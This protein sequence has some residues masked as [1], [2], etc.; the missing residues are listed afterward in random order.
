[1]PFLL[2]LVLSGCN[3]STSVKVKALI[4]DLKGTV[5]PAPGVAL[6]ALPY[7]RDSLIAALEARAPSPRPSTA[8]LDSLYAGVRRPFTAYAAVSESVATLQDS[9]ARL[10]AALDSLSREA[11]QYRAGYTAFLDVSAHRS[12][13]E[14]RQTSARRVLDRARTAAAPRIDS[15]RGTLRAWEDSAYADYEKLTD[16]LLRRATVQAVADT[17][18]SDGTAALTLPPGRDGRWWIYART[19]DAEDPNAEWYWNVPVSG[20]TVVLGPENA[21]RRVRY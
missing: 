4:P 1:L 10:K 20:D 6:V 14:A 17:T 11:P 8:L 5:A 7:D 12:A 21:R 18:G 9:A 3:T 13:L 19:W 15:S 16:A 2:A